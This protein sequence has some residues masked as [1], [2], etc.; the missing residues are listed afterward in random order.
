MSNRQSDKSKFVLWAT[1]LALFACA[2]VLFHFWHKWDYE[3]SSMAA[4]GDAAAPIVGI[5]SLLAVGVALWTVEIQKAAL[6]QQSKHQ[7]AAMTLQRQALEEQEKHILEQQKATQIQ[8]AL[9]QKDFD[10]RRRQD[11]NAVLR[12]AYIPFIVELNELADVMQHY[13]TRMS[14]LGFNIED[15]PSGK[16]KK[17]WQQIDAVQKR[18]KLAA[19][20]V[21]FTETGTERTALLF[22]LHGRPFR[23]PAED[24]PSP[25]TLQLWNDVLAYRVLKLKVDIQAVELSLHNELLE[26]SV[27]NR[28][29]NI[30]VVVR[31]IEILK[32]RAEAAEV[33]IDA[34]EAAYLRK[35]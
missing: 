19:V 27:V 31:S 18:V 30:S 7:D 2:G 16:F 26:Q 28:A 14:N 35:H 12:A 11:K 21:R 20:N 10:E 29:A 24:V 22:E 13:Q 25:T 6:K 3:M 5:F 1:I 9:Q 33:K 4:V 15:L 32:A 34:D 17:M 8:L 23:A